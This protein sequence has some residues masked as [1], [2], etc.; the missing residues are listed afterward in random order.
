MSAVEVRRGRWGFLG[1]LMYSKVSPGGTVPG[2]VPVSVGLDQKSLT[3]QGN[4]FYR[5]YEDPGVK[6]DLGAGLRYWTIDSDGTVSAGL[7]G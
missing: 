3:L 1:D 5:V 7:P 6:V 4:A 2:T